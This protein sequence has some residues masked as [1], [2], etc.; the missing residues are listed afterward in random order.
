MKTT[1]ILFVLVNSIFNP[2]FSQSID[3]LKFGEF[4]KCTDLYEKIDNSLIGEINTNIYTQS[5]D[6][7]TIQFT[8]YDLKGVR[9]KWMEYSFNKRYSGFDL[10]KI[11]IVNSGICCVFQSSVKKKQKRVKVIL[12]DPLSLEITKEKDFVFNCESKKENKLKITVSED[13]SKIALLSGAPTYRKKDEFSEMLLGEDLELRVMDSNFNELNYKRISYPKEIK[14][15][16]RLDYDLYKIGVS[17]S[18]SFF[19]SLKRERDEKLRRV[20]I[21]IDVFKTIK[22]EVSEKEIEDIIERSG[23]KKDKYQILISQVK[24]SGEMNFNQISLDDFNVI[25]Y[26]FL[27]NDYGEL[28]IAGLGTNENSKLIGSFFMAYDCQTKETLVN[29]INVF[30]NKDINFGNAGNRCKLQFDEKGGY[31]LHFDNIIESEYSD[32]AGGYKIF[33]SYKNDNFVMFNLDG[34]YK[35][36]Y[37]FNSTRNDYKYSTQGN[38]SY[39]YNEY[40]LNVYRTAN[41]NGYDSNGI[42]YEGE[43]K[44]TKASIEFWLT[45][46]TIEK[47]IID[48]LTGNISHSLYVSD[49]LPKKKHINFRFKLRPSS[50]IFLNDTFYMYMQSPFEKAIVMVKE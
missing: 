45:K 44:A 5:V 4:E 39:N 38:I 41:L 47:T 20:L 8:K 22:T 21:E 28:F 40:G 50:S 37:H 9:Q 27:V 30:Q 32:G 31:L 12:L 49:I 11:V 19:F 17:N 14:D 46:T 43:R 15:E 3:T 34:E 29:S 7:N 33:I 42:R 16:K 36:D 35:W 24:L 1:L 48:N 2:L 25:D 26:D 13:G 10:K 6:G 18:G 23:Y